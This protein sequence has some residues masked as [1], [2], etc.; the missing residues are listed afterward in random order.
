MLEV[1]LA[2]VLGLHGG[3]LGGVLGHGALKF[4]DA[5]LGD[6]AGW[7][8]NEPHTFQNGWGS[9]RRLCVLW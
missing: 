3:I 9:G 2:V 5:V 6:W 7:V 4:R 1:Q 8:P